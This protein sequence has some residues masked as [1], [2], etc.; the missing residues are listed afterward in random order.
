MVNSPFDP[1]NQRITQEK[2][3]FTVSANK[4]E[5]VFYKSGEDG[6]IS[7]IFVYCNS[8]QLILELSMGTDVDSMKILDAYNWNLL[9]PNTSFYLTKYDTSNNLYGIA[10]QPFNPQFYQGSVEIALRN[11][12]S[13]DITVT[14]VIFKK[15]VKKTLVPTPEYILPGQEFSDVAVILP[16]EEEIEEE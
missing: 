4:E 6:W 11:N 8:S 7:E 10:F 9:Y 3:N 15:I 12:S 14:K 1:I 5:S 13:S 2:S 16:E